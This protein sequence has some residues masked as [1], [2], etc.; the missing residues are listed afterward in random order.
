MTTDIT[1]TKKTTDTTDH[2]AIFTTASAIFLGAFPDATTDTADMV[3]SSYRSIHATK[4]GPVQQSITMDAMT[5]GVST[6]AVV[7]W[8]GILADAVVAKSTRRTVATDAAPKMIDAA[9]GIGIVA[10]FVRAMDTVAR[11]MDKG[12]KPASGTKTAVVD[13]NGNKVTL[14]DVVANGKL[15][16]GDTVHHGKHKGTIVA[17]DDGYG[18]K[19]GGKVYVSPTMAASVHVTYEV[20]G[21]AWWK[22]ADGTAIGSLR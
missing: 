4:R 11:R 16:V 5:S 19:T 22:T 9:F 14:A 2:A 21:W 12:R 15:T 6:E 17:T 7:A 8:L 20:N 18:I 1:T 3:A 13:G 10:S